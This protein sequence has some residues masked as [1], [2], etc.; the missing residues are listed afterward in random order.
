MSRSI[1]TG[2]GLLLV[3]GISLLLSLTFCPPVAPLGSDIEFFRYG[4]RVLLHGG[5]PYKDF[6][7]H[8]PPMIFFINAAGELIGPWGQWILTASLALAVTWLFYRLCLRHRVNYPWLL[9]VLFNLMLR[10]NLICEGANYTREYSIY[11]VLFFFC[12]MMGEGRC[13]YWWLGFFTGMTF[14]STG[15]GAAAGAF[16]GLCAL[17]KGSH[18]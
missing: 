8:K 4:G 10:D 17:G 18:P 9:P 15:T 1:Y 12:A 2:Y 6:F 3:L 11:F 14:Y 7:D 16:P 5:A 13:R